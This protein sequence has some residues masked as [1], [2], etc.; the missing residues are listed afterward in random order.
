MTFSASNGAYSM[1]KSI[2]A[3]ML[4]AASICVPVGSCARAA[5]ANNSN[6]SL[7]FDGITLWGV[8]D[9]GVAHQ[10]RG[11]PLNPDYYTG[12]EYVI[13]KNSGRSVTTIAPSGLSQSKVVLSGFEPFAG[14]RQ[15]GEFALVFKLETDFN[16]ESVSL[17]N[18][19][20]ALVDN[21]G[22]PLNHQTTDA[23]GNKNGQI[24]GGS[25]YGGISSEKFG[26]LT[27]GRQTSALSDALYQYDPQMGS[28]AFS[29]LGYSGFI[30]GGGDTQDVRLDGTLKYNVSYG[31]VH[32]AALFQFPGVDGYAGGAQQVT[33]G[34]NY[35]SFAADFG[36]SHV[37]DAVSAS[38]LTTAQI[39]DPLVPDNSLAATVSDNTAFAGMAKYTTKWISLYGGYEH[40]TYTNPAH[41]LTNGFVDEGGYY[42][43]NLLT[44]N[45]AY[46]DPRKVNVLWTGFRFPATSALTLSGA[47][48]H[49]FQDS[50]RAGGTCFSNVSAQ[51]AGHEDAIS[52]V[53]DYRFNKNWDAYVGSMYS[54]VAGGMANGF[55][56]NETDGTMAGARFSF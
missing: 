45:N 37:A 17:G 43:T 31:I 9:M 20:Q 29:V 50:Y 7:T 34:I 5:D 38:S 26:V 28:Y 46:V 3:F 35:G 2:A 15:L 12:L 16:P 23:D 49:L 11:T 32:A 4:T 51:C 52:L 33:A 53:L 48:Y 18:S 40:I 22:L 21:A 25:A 42:V 41:P 8:I 14:N 30:A 13:S 27:A 36:Y 19:S 6:G 39:D 56:S 1:T 10:T 55:L 24:F 54:V 44:T 47:Y